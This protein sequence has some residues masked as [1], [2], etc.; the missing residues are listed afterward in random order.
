MFTVGEMLR[1]R[2]DFSPHQEAVVYEDERVTYWE[3]NRRVNRLAHFM[4]ELDVQK[5][6][7]IAILCST[8]HP[9]ATVLLAAAKLGVVAVPL[10]WRLSLEELRQ[11]MEHSEPKLLFFDEEFSETADE[12]ESCE[13]L[14]RMVRVSIDQKLNPPFAEALLE[15]PDTEP[16]LPVDPED[17]LALTYTSGTT[18]KPKGVITTHANFHAFGVAASLTL[19]VRRGDRFLIS[20]PLFRT[21]GLSA[22]VNALLLGGTV[23]FM[24]DFHPVR[25][26]EVVERERINHLL[27][28]P[29]MLS[30]MLPGAMNRDWDTGSMRDF[31][32]GGPV[33][34]EVIRQYTSL[35]FPIVQMYG[36]SEVAGGITFWNPSMGISTSHSA[37]KKLLGEI[38]VVD[39]KSGEDVSPGEIGEILYRGPQVTP[40]YWKDP[41][42]TERVIQD[43]WF[44]TGDIGRLEEDGLLYVMDRSSDL[45]Y[46]NEELVLPSEVEKVLAGM[47]GVEEVAVIGV[48]DSEKGEVPRA[49]VVKEEN[50]PVTEEDVLRYGRE[51]LVEHQL[52]EVAF[53]DMLPRNSLGLI[54]KY[55]LREQVER[56]KAIDVGE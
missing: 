11:G 54:T 34:E 7:R 12:L 48:K 47:E 5:G 1:N 33:T 21:N 31:I 6:D 45:I 16:D 24:P 18:G 23:V 43:G 53:V 41:E 42:E 27:S 2:A 56:I 49:Y 52:M 8:N 44:H 36:A 17:P 3:L 46:C 20:T 50:S 25:A 10:N 32:C 29:G 39:P 40:G 19:D 22:M 13:F 51:R 38:K 30:Y 9:F 4:M 28:L 37:G 15:Y 26:W 55:I 14:E 35:G